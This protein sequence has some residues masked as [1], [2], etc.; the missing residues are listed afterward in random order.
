MLRP[1][2]TLSLQI[3]PP[4]S[5]HYLLRPSESVLYLCSISSSFSPESSA[6]TSSSKN[7]DRAS[8][9][10]SG[11]TSLEPLKKQCL[12]RTIDWFTYSFCH[13]AEIK[14]FRA[15][16]GTN[17]QGRTPAPDPKEESYVLGRFSPNSEKVYGSRS[18]DDKDVAGTS[19]S[20]TSNS[21]AQVYKEKTLNRSK[22]KRKRKMELNWWR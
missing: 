19:L 5:T 1:F 8:V 21:D 20:S 12:Y 13:G 3:F 18:S 22:P 9:L 4:S 17:I 2:W 15:L 14:Q 7:L 10:Q 11:L 6:S 16:A